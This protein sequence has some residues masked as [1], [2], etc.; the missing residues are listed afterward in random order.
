[1]PVSKGRKP[2]PTPKISAPKKRPPALPPSSKKWWARVAG[3]LTFGMAVVGLTIAIWPKLTIEPTKDPQASNPFSAA[4]KVTNGQFYPIESVHI[5][6]YLWCVKMGTGTDTTPPRMCVR[7]LP[8]SKRQWDGDIG[9]YGS[10]DIVLEDVLFATPNF[11]LYA[12]ISIKVTYQLWI[13]PFPRELER[14][15]YSR[16]KDDGQIEW[17]NK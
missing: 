17:L 4:F 7:G 10:R 5:Q 2:K 15:F 8:S 3:I 11:I 12:E 13:V 6:A 16:R 9:P 14:R 1:M